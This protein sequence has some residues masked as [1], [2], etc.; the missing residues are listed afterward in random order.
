MTEEQMTDQ[1]IADKT[2]Q[3]SLQF[4][5]EAVESEVVYI[6]V[7]ENNCLQTDSTEFVDENEE[8][9]V[10]VPVW[11]KSFVEHAK[12][13][14]GEEGVAEEMTLDYF[15]NEFIPQL[16]E[17]HCTIGLN[18]DN[19]GVGREFSPFDLTDML[20][21]KINGEAVELPD[22]SMDEDLEAHA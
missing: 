13:W 2:D 15:L 1:A 6:L 11:T 19:E 21:K 12:K 17:S 7:M 4:I 9:L 8:P 10:A 3:D 16:E 20:V 22:H 14:A 18:W 5:T